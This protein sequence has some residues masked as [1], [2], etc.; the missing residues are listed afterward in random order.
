[1]GYKIKRI[2]ENQ[3]HWGDVFFNFCK[4]LTINALTW[5]GGIDGHG[6]GDGWAWQARWMDMAGTVNRF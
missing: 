4:L 6:R 5:T 1:M 2:S 3:K